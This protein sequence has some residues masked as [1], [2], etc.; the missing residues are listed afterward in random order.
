MQGHE[1]KYS[2]YVHASEKA[3]LGSIWKSKVFKGRE[4][5]SEKVCMQGF[6]FSLLN[7]PLV[8]RMLPRQVEVTSNC[9]LT[10]KPNQKVNFVSSPA[11]A[12]MHIKRLFLSF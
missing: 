4:I 7:F 3:S 6:F 11:A 10:T 1:G 9:A 2:V 8:F 5:R 12:A